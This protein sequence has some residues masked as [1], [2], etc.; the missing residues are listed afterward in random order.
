MEL[1]TYAFQRERF[2]L[3]S[4]AG[5]GDFA[6]AGQGDAEHPLL[7]AAVRLAG[8]QGW[9]FT[10]RVSLG[11]DAWLRDH[12]VLGAV[13]LPGTAFVEL[14]LAAA[15][16]VGAGGVEDLALV[17]PLVLAGERAV[18]LQVAVGESDEDGRRPVNVY[19]CPDGEDLGEAVWSLHASGLLCAAGEI[20][21][22]DVE[23]EPFAWP[24]EGAEEVEVEW[25]YDRL[26]D[27]G[28]DYGPAFQGLRAAY[29]SG[30]VW[31]AEVALSGELEVQAGGFCVHP[32]LADAALHTVALAALDQADA[33]DAPAVPFSFSG[34]RV[35]RD[36]AAAL[37]VRVEVVQD[38]VRL[39]A[40]DEAGEPA[41]AIE[42]LTA[43]AVDPAALQAR[44]NANA[45]SLYAVQWVAVEQDAGAAE[46]VVE[47]DDGGVAAL[48]QAISDGAAAPGVVLMRAGAL[49]GSVHE[50]SERALELLKAWLASEP[51]ADARLVLVTDAALV[52]AAGES[53]NLVQAP[54]VGLV[55]SAASESPLRFG[56]VDLDGAQASDAALAGAVASEEPELALRDGVLY[57]PRLVRARSAPEGGL[58]PPAADS[59]W[60]LGIERTGSLEDLE[61]VPVQDAPLGEG[62]VR[63]AVRAAGLNF[64][65]VLIALGVY[66]GEAPLGSEAA[67]VVVEVAAG[68]E[69]LC[70]GDRVMGLIADGFGTHAIADRRALVEIPEGWSFGQAASVSVVFLTAYYGLFDIAGLQ[71]GERV[72]IHAA[73]GGVGM[74]ALQ[75]A[76]HVGAEVFATA[77]PDKWDVLRGLGIDD[78]HIASSRSLSFATSSWSAPAAR[79]WTWCW[80]RWRASSLTRRLSC[81]QAEAG[82]WRSARPMF[83]TPTRSRRS[84]RASATGR[85]TC[86]RPGPT[87]SKSCWPRCWS[88]SSGA[89]SSTSRSR[90]STCA[91]RQTRSDG[92]AR[93]DTSASSC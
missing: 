33:G 7:G 34:V 79:A 35:I 1:P 77:H 40:L 6:A 15:R 27:R 73:A 83:V 19:S 23:F 66:P 74:A 85:L 42:S 28:Y 58:I 82:S 71:R 45:D 31:F 43:R 72:L 90:A 29:R 49:G 84:T 69:D 60:R 86:S 80:T 57:A 36:G 10:G 91:A 88:C 55:R 81:C 30:D 62:Q 37:R 75:L 50:T 18:R 76:R 68:V 87:A 56:V 9:V 70:V 65:D 22:G 89:R 78:E 54:V 39:V 20:A 17:A 47:L 8:D 61:L 51:L 53:P 25:L 92:C 16:H 67:G 32:A 14:A 24:P 41:L 63:V 93:A 11:T 46:A 4:S 64:R 44:A 5:G 38:G 48:E 2:W 12:V 13:L 26:A 59:R 21:G 3:E 52:V